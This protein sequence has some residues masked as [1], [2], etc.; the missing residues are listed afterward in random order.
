MYQ[1]KVLTSLRKHILRRRFRPQ[2]H[3]WIWHGE[4]GFTKKKVF[5]RICM[6]KVLLIRWKN[7]NNVYQTDEDNVNDDVDCVDEIIE[8]VEDELEKRIC[9]PTL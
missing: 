9:K 1:S 2:Y 7:N 4:E 5:K 6:K 8:G 3:V